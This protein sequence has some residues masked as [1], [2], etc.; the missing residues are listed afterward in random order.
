MPLSASLKWQIPVLILFAALFSLT[1][2]LLPPV[3]HALCIEGGFYR[4]FPLAF[5][6]QCYE[7]GPGGPLS[8]SDLDWARLILDVGFWYLAS[9]GVVRIYRW[10]GRP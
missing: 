8:T 1:S 6:Y 3:A 2:I 4:G 10:I 5:L 7:G 9:Y